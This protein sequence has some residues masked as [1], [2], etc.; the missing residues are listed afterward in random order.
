MEAGLG[1]IKGRG[2]RVNPEN[3]FD[4]LHLTYDPE[5]SAGR[6]CASEFLRDDSQSIITHNNSPDLSFG[7]SLNPYRGCEHGCAYCYA[8][9]YHEYLG[10]SAGLDFESKI[11]VKHEAPQLLEKELGSPRYRPTVLA[12][13]GVTDPYQPVERELMITR[14]CL[15]VLAGFRNP[16]ALITKNA[17]VTRDLDHLRELAR[18]QA[19]AVFVSVTSLDPALARVL[20]PRASSP[21]A[22]LAAVREL[23]EAGVPVGVSA[24]PMIPGLNDHELP[25]ILE[26]AAEAGASFGFYSLVRLPGTVAPVFE[27]WMEEHFPDRKDKVLAR[28][29]AA[30]GGRLNNTTPGDR[31]RGRG[32]HAEQLRQ[33]FLATRRRVGLRASPPPLKVSHFRRLLPGQPELF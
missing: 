27:S 3:R 25:A 12:L 1:R 28:I 29:R 21:R 5:E 20:E 24:A 11:L 23:A 8:R 26:A 9:T 7:A 19:V 4:S 33:L 10:Y 15:Q 2:C 16:V 18:F 30:H 22:R 31:F 13:S 17:L 14:G 6:G 32:I